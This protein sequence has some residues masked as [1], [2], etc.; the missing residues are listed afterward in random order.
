MGTT[1]VR[2]FGI[3]PTAGEV[4]DFSEE[5]G[6]FDTV[7][8]DMGFEKAGSYQWRYRDE[9]CVLKVDLTRSKDG[10]HCWLTVQ[11][12]DEHEHRAQEVAQLLTAH[13]VCQNT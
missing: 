5:I 3:S 6:Y 1:K 10:F 12:M 8:A 11:A 13:L 9:E 7:F 4:L 2:K